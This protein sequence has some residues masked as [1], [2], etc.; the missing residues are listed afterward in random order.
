MRLTLNDIK[1]NLGIDIGSSVT[2]QP[3]KNIVMGSNTGTPQPMKKTY[4]PKNNPYF[5]SKT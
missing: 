5:L 4:S 3:K 2:I 1:I